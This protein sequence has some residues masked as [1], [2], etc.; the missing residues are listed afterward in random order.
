MKEIVK[1]EDQ[2]RS[3]V[4]PDSRRI[5]MDTDALPAERVP[6]NNVLL[7]QSQLVAEVCK[8]STVHKRKQLT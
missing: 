8:K 4:R 6:L 2:V 3:S 5:K 7:S 1:T